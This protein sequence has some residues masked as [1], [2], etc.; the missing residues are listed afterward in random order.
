MVLRITQKNYLRNRMDVYPLGR[1]SVRSSG[2]TREHD[3]PSGLSRYFVY[4]LERH[5]ESSIK[6]RSYVKCWSAER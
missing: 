2:Q 5:T 4:T 3:S 1:G 6:L